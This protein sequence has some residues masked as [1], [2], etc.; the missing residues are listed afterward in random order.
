MYTHTGM[1]RVKSIQ[2]FTQKWKTFNKTL[3]FM[4]KFSY[5]ITYIYIYIYQF[6]KS[7]QF[8]VQKIFDM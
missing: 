4:L 5:K 1:E 2:Y 3:L 6:L 8:S 7:I